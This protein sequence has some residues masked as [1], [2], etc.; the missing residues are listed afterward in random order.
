M[1][2]QYSEPIGPRK[3]GTPPA[4]T[5]PVSRR[6]IQAAVD[7]LAGKKVINNKQIAAVVK[8]LV[9]SGAIR[10]EA[11]PVVSAV[12]VNLEDI[13]ARRDAAQRGSAMVNPLDERY[14]VGGERTADTAE[15]REAFAAVRGVQKGKTAAAKVE[16]SLP[17]ALYDATLE[18]LG[19]PSGK[20]LADRIIRREDRA[21][22]LPSPSRKRDGVT[23]APITE[24]QQSGED[25]RIINSLPQDERQALVLS[26]RHR[27]NEFDIAEQMGITPKHAK[28]L[29]RK[30][31]EK[32]TSAF[33][34]FEKKTRTRLNKEKRRE[35]YE[36]LMKQARSAFERTESREADAPNTP[37]TGPGS[38][39]SY[40]PQ[41]ARGRKLP[42]PVTTIKRNRKGEVESGG[43]PMSFTYK[44]K[45]GEEVP[46]YYSRERLQKEYDARSVLP[47]ESRPPLEKTALFRLN[48]QAKKG[49]FRA[50]VQLQRELNRMFGERGTYEPSPA[51]KKVN[52]EWVEAK[53]RRIKSVAEKRRGRNFQEAKS[54]G[55]GV[56]ELSKGVQKASRPPRLSKE[57]RR[58]RA[59]G[60]EF[61]VSD[62]RAAVEGRG[63]LS[64]K[65]GSEQAAELLRVRK[66]A[67]IELESE[68]RKGRIG[69]LTEQMQARIDEKLVDRMSEIMSTR[70]RRRD[71][72]DTSG[73][74]IG[75]SAPVPSPDRVRVDSSPKARPS[76]AEL[77]E[78]LQRI[79]K[80]SGMKGVREH[81]KP[82]GPQPMDVVER[83]APQQAPNRLPRARR[84]PIITRPG[85]GQSLKEHAFSVLAKRFG[86]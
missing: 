35:M 7:A 60:V 34:E 36:Q 53:P 31:N 19:S 33:D 32:I 48:E 73:L 81:Y 23:R 79:Q 15:E 50:A 30:A 71:P 64:R 49:D 21:D 58:A 14:F 62:E 72:E 5:P 52:G 63:K 2:K 39:Q 67:E 82:I 37:Y 59:E 76:I 29:I 22:R 38:P 17:P 80:A 4:D 27:Q 74:P 61:P 69:P 20:K 84:K 55:M 16:T 24:I 41:Q 3:M 51:M 8:Q 78:R 75:R 65:V 44:T 83:P 18:A 56:S 86:R 68:F 10:A 9:A 6:E 45:E 43:K 12:L 28:D 13:V 46:K 66:Q 11:G 1:E 47:P 26:V 54:L 57:E 70:N 25:R 85:R 42:R 77:L 40:P